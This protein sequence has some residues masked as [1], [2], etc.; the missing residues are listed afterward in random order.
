MPGFP[1][2]PGDFFFFPGIAQDKAVKMGIFGKPLPFRGT[3][4]GF[5][6]L[7]GISWTGYIQREPGLVFAGAGW[8]Y[9]ADIGGIAIDFCLPAVW[10]VA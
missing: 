4:E 8:G 6:K 9:I 2:I 10:A 1:G 7:K 5:G 3:C